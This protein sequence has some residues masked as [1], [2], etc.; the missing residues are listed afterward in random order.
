M[1][2]QSSS[3]ETAQKPPTGSPSGLN[4]GES[5][6][7]EVGEEVTFDTQPIEGRLPNSSYSSRDTLFTWMDITGQ[8]GSVVGMDRQAIFSRSG[9][10]LGD[11]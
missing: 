7:S 4:T 9:G 6:G 11:L 1:E 10:C 3:G 2:S 8:S 5:N